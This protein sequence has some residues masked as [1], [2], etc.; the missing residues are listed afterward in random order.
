VYHSE[1]LNH[2]VPSTGLQEGR[3]SQSQSDVEETAEDTRKGEPYYVMMTKLNESHKK[4][5]FEQ[6]ERASASRKQIFDYYETRYQEHLEQ[7]RGKD[8]TIGH[9]RKAAFEM[10]KRGRELRGRVEVMEAEKE[11]IKRTVTEAEEK[12]MKLAKDHGALAGKLM[13]AEAC[14]KQFTLENSELRMKNDCLEEE[15][16]EL[17]RQRAKENEQ[18]ANIETELLSLKEKIAELLP[19]QNQVEKAERTMRYQERT[20]YNT[21]LDNSKLSKEKESLTNDLA[22]SLRES[23]ASRLRLTQLLKEAYDMHKQSGDLVEK[24]GAEVKELGLE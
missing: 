7:V 3:S 8:E 5:M 15:M 16:L 23:R 9:L 14:V 18:V 19:L 20:L 4:E 13:E 12:G 2:G 10:G 21:K 17:R 6:R 1:D 22:K 24:L 11:A